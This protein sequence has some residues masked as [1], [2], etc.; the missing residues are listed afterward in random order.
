MQ[1]IANVFVSVYGRVSAGLRRQSSSL[2][3]RVIDSTKGIMATI[4]RD[5]DSSILEH[6]V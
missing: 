2:V 4:A 3:Q 1:C 5:Y 6:W